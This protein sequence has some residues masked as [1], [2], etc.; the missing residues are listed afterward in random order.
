[1]DDLDLCIENY[2]L[3]DILKL[4][5]LDIN[6]NKKDLLN[7]KKIVLKMHPDKSK[8]KK[9]YFLFFSKAYKMLYKVYE[10]KIKSEKDISIENDYETN[11]IDDENDEAALKKL[12]Y[13][14]SFSRIFNEMFEKY[15][16]D[17]RT[18]G[19]GDWLKSSDE[20]INQ[21]NNL[22]EVNQ[23]INQ[24]KNNLR[25][26]IKYDGIKEV[27]INAG[28]SLIEEGNN[29]SS[30]MFGNLLF[31]DLKNA[32]TETVVPVTEEDYNLRKKYKNIDEFNIER[33]NLFIKEMK[34]VD[35]D[36][37]L[38]QKDKIELEKN[39]TRAYELARK[40]ENMGYLKNKM[41]SSLLR[42][43]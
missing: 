21:A 6:F 36:V 31:D 28:S 32:Y 27:N 33:N 7:A 4:F 1:M 14:K 13:D 37:I 22:N 40:D 42:I 9:E 30:D 23:Y 3:N 41:K 29:F 17:L 19:H 26:I 5:K 20:P 11:D 15:N 25:Q 39:L 24:K 18:D 38:K 43:T 12:S 16:K 10:F 34:T 8:L 2:D 35:H